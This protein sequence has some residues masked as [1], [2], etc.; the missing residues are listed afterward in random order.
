MNK[1]LRITILFSLLAATLLSGCG[2]KTTEVVSILPTTDSPPTASPTLE[3][4]VTPSP[5]PTSLPLNGQ[6]TVYE[7]N[8]TID[9]YNRFITVTSRS[10]Y[11]NRTNTPINEMVFVV[12]PIIF[13][14]AIYM[15]SVTHGD[16]TPVTNYTWDKF[17]MVIPLATPLQPGGQIEF[18][19]QFELYMWAR[20]DYGGV[21]SQNGQ[22]LNLSYWFPMIPPFS[23]TDG[24]IAHDVNLVNSTFVGEFLVFEPADY[25]VTLQFTDRR[26]N[27]KIAAPALPTEADGV[28]TYQLDLSRTFTLSISDI[29]TV[30]EREVN[31]VKI[32]SFTFN[33]HSSVVN[34]VADLAVQAMTLYSELFGEYD[35]PVLSVVEFNSDI[36]MEFD[37]L[38]FL[39]PYFYNLYPGTPKSNIHVYTAHEIAHQWFFAIVGNDQ[40]QDPWLDEAFATYAEDLFYER[41]YP[42]YRDWHWENYITA[43]NPYGKIDISIYEGGELTEYRNVVYRNG[44]VFLKQLRAT[45]GDEAFFS[46][47]KDYVRQNRYEIATTEKFWD[48]LLTHTDVDLT[49]LHNEYFS[50]PAD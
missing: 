11:T 4:T 41:F 8:A 49:A 19:H 46:F 21:F 37:G 40:A 32:Q 20:G 26:E 24:W 48:I 29:F 25:T 34:V 28:I 50:T 45:I 35:K 9:Y 6:E 1:T 30:A 36:G 27:F 38:V 31:G 23:E 44:A 42:E 16:G 7:V 2:P 15:K 47:L 18:V 5:T 13:Q 10:R 14:D 12:Y 33:E 3:P 22:Q 17:R 39:S 43:H